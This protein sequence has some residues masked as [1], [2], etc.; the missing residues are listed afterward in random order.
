VNRWCAFRIDLQA[1][2]IASLFALFAIFIGKSD[3]PDSLA[4]MAIGLQL[5]TEVA[6]NFN[7]AVRWTATFEN[8]MVSVQRLLV[9]TE[10][11]N[12]N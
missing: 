4:M 3:D 12:E 7:T 10:L 1:Y 9:Y 5:A 11:K 6:R 2:Y 8:D